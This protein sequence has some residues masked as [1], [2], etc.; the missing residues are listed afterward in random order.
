MK[1]IK[2]V[3]LELV[4]CV[5]IPNVKDMEFGKFYYSDEYKTAN[6]LCPCGCGMQTPLPIG[7]GEWQLSWTE[8]LK[9]TVTPSILHRFGCES[10]YIITN[11][12]ANIV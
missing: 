3:P 2:R 4:L 5:Y 1:T 10:H 9:I 6:H 8:D 12:G 11:G 7:P